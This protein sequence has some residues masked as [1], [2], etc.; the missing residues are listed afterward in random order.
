MT[1]PSSNCRHQ[2]K[3]AYLLDREILLPPRWLHNT[4]LAAE[5]FAATPQM[6]FQTRQ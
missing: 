6:S 2:A 1:C 4:F 3:I 5:R